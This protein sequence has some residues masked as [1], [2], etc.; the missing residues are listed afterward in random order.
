MENVRQRTARQ[1][2]NAQK[3]AVEPIIKSLLDVAD[4]LQ[5]AAE[6][7][8]AGVVDGDEQLEAE[9]AQRLLKSL[10]QGVRM[11]EGVL[12]NVFKKHGVEQYNPAGEKFDPNLHQAM[13][14]VPDGTKEAGLVAV[15]TKV[16]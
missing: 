12:I 15:V 13:F 9:K 3:F 5:R 6:A 16:I 14:E 11:T 8:P 7:V 2:E 1:I 4:N 10:L